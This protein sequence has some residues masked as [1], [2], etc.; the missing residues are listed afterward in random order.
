MVCVPCGALA[1][2]QTSLHGALALGARAIANSFH[3]PSGDFLGTWRAPSLY[4]RLSH[5]ANNREH[6]KQKG[7][8]MPTGT[9]VHRCVQRLKGKRGINAYAVC[10]ASTGQSYATGKR[11]KKRKTKRKRKRGGY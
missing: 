3:I 6:C 11:T 10:Q 9:K 1:I 5:I 7:A 4:V 8:I 2:D